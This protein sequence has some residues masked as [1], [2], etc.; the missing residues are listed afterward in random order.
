RKRCRW[1]ALI[2]SLWSWTLSGCC[3]GQSRR[4]SPSNTPCSPG[5]RQAGATAY[6]LLT[7]VS[8]KIQRRPNIE[9]FHQQGLLGLMHKTSLYLHRPVRHAATRQYFVFGDIGQRLG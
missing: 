4:S 3:Y 2:S 5:T 1:P 7:P 6:T 8:P 9:L